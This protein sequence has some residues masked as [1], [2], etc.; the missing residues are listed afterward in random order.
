MA[1]GGR[2]VVA[3][4][5]RWNGKCNVSK[6]D[7][8][9]D[10]EKALKERDRRNGPL[11]SSDEVLKRGKYAFMFRDNYKVYDLTAEEVVHY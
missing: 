5:I 10:R 11:P 1:R 9:A 3:R 2:Y 8:F 4:F 7:S 6:D